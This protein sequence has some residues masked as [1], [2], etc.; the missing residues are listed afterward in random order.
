M[1]TPNR[2]SFLSFSHT[3]FGVRFVL[4]LC[5]RAWMADDRWGERRAAKWWAVVMRREVCSW[6]LF[7]GRLQSLHSELKRTALFLMWIDEKRW[8]WVMD[9]CGTHAAK[10]TLTNFEYGSVAV[11]LKRQCFDVH[12]LLRFMRLSV[13]FSRYFIQMQ[14]AGSF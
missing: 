10:H 11:W 13:R 8:R 2:S 4:F 14:S 12:K 9:R 5:R 7:C 6:N 1:V 3:V